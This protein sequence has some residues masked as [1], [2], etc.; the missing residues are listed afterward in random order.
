M[1]ESASDIMAPYILIVINVI[2][3]TQVSSVSRFNVEL[4]DVLLIWKVIYYKCFMNNSIINQQIIFTVLFI[5]HLLHL[6]YSQYLQLKIFP[7]W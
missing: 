1:H 3:V 7:P 2:L 6:C 4:K 5:N